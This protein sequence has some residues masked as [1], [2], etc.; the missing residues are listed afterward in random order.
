MI[1][2]SSKFTARGQTLTP[3]D[4]H[5]AEA[6]ADNNLRVTV[7]SMTSS[8]RTSGLPKDQ[9]EAVDPSTRPL[10]RGQTRKLYSL[11]KLQKM[12]T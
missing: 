4:L 9:D 6:N 12:S 7:G 8:T 5:M 3:K 11:L 1:T 10:T 2:S